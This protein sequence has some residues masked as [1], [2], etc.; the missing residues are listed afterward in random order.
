[1][2]VPSSATSIRTHA[3]GDLRSEHA[4][5]V[6]RLGGWVHRARDLGG[7]VFLD[8]RDRAGIVQVSFDPQRGSPELSARA[9]ALGAETVV[10]IEG[11][12]VERPAT[13]RNAD[14]PTGEIEVRGTE[15]R[16]VGPASIPVIPVAR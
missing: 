16:I 7:L 13:M 9:A 2:S 10:V 1:M 8:L 15:L 5:Q 12:V 11:E 3:C 4:G 14:L 6:V